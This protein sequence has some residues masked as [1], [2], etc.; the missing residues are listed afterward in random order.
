MNQY[1]EKLEQ[2][3]SLPIFSEGEERLIQRDQLSVLL[4][5]IADNALKI[6]KRQYGPT[7]IIDV[8]G[9][10][11]CGKTTLCK[12]AYCSIKSDIQSYTISGLPRSEGDIQ[13]GS[14]RFPNGEN[15]MLYCQF[16]SSDKKFNLEE[17]LKFCIDNKRFL[18]FLDDIHYI[19]NYQKD[20]Y[21]IQDNF[22][23]IILVIV[24]QGTSLLGR[25]FVGRHL[26]I[27][28]KPFSFRELYLS[29][30]SIFT[31]IG[32]RHLPIGKVDIEARHLPY[33]KVDIEARRLHEGKT[34]TTT[35]LEVFMRY[36]G[37]PEVSLNFF[38]V[39][40]KVQQKLSQI[41]EICTECIEI[42]DQEKLVNFFLDLPPRKNTLYKQLLQADLI[43]E[44]GDGIYP[45][46][47]G[48][49]NAIC[50]SPTLH[51]KS[52]ETL[53]YWHLR[54]QGKAMSKVADNIIMV[55]WNQFYLIISQNAQ[56]SS[57]V[58]LWETGHRGN[59]VSEVRTKLI[60]G[61]TEMVIIIHEKMDENFKSETKVSDLK[62][63]SPSFFDFKFSFAVIQMIP[64][65][66][67]TSAAE[68]LSSE[69]SPNQLPLFLDSAKYLKNIMTLI[70]K[71]NDKD[72]RPLAETL[73]VSLVDSQ[74][75][76]C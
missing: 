30:L 29:D 61:L 59:E 12:Q 46:D 2:Y 45:A 40:E 60:E 34:D 32:A 63:N 53:V 33:G 24:G 19:K 44:L 9:I 75:N 65:F 14:C 56:R 4:S 15:E 66:F 68:F 8:V 39:E 55:N 20:L 37:I 25:S 13:S 50:K 47:A 21:R 57:P 54:L 3:L 11:R 1:K 17:F 41:A 74:I 36:G 7:Q 6:I 58:S 18:F 76:G 73:V 35:C 26:S 64:C 67:G 69:C 72:L 70:R 5:Y 23:K 52:L 43:S 10:R 27:A 71:C 42:D 62:S 49:L 31:D 16:K 22:P 28:L 48:I 38:D 51:E